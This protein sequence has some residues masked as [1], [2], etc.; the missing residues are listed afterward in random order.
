MLSANFG[1]KVLQVSQDYGSL[2]GTIVD[3]ERPVA[4]EH[5]FDNVPGREYTFRWV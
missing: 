1:F 4:E 5:S 2:D 3:K